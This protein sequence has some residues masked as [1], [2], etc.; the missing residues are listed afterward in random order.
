MS[1]VA[2]NQQAITIGVDPHPKTHTACALDNNG[3]IH[4]T[5]TISSDQAGAERLLEWAEQFSSR[6]WA[7]EGAGNKFVSPLIE[8]LAQQ[9]EAV[10]NI[11]PAMT[12]QYRSV[13]G[14]KKTDEIDATNAARALLANPQMSR[15]QRCAQQR[16]LQELTRAYRRVS[17]QLKAQ[18][19]TLRQCG[20]AT[21]KEALQ[22]VIMALEASQAQLRRSLQQLLQKRHPE[23]LA[24][25]GVGVIVAAVIIAEVGSVARFGGRDQF[26]SFGGLAPIQRLSGCG[27]GVRVNAGGNRRLNWAVHMMVKS[28][29]GVD[30]RSRAYVERKLGEGKTRREAIR[31]LKT[32]AARE[33]Y[34]V[35]RRSMVARAAV[36]A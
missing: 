28:R 10:F 15:Y 23:L 34:G 18:R 6:R 25:R 12:A 30:E 4:A 27:G 36:G 35:L 29:L 2:T 32:L 13:R 22:R 31:C 1:S 3:L 17:D 8:A 20:S 16:E 26:V 21:V 11:P 24:V 5:I 14:R 7:I 9:D 33:I 19:M